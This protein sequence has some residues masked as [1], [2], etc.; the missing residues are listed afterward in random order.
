MRKSPFST[1]RGGNRGGINWQSNERPG[2]RGYPNQTGHP[3]FAPINSPVIK[4][5]NSMNDG[6]FIAFNNTNESPSTPQR[7]NFYRGRGRGN[8]FFNNP[9]YQNRGNNS[10]NPRGHYSSYNQRGWN[11]KS[12][13]NRGKSKMQINRETPASE[14]F[15]I[16]SC[17]ED[18][19]K[20]L[21][22][23]NNI[24]VDDKSTIIDAK[25]DSM[26]CE[27]NTIEVDDNKL[28]NDIDK[29]DSNL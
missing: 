14:F 17:L 9:G 12:N 4:L 21:M 26:D 22:D 7:S 16:P 29:L 20:N 27:I 1:P 18:P 24:D 6:D 10:F 2:N 3:N 28:G 5:N 8:R 23:K 11:K 19:W 13:N 15:H 25:N